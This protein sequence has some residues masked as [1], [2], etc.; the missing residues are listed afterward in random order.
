VLLAVFFG[1]LVF[2]VNAA[3]KKYIPELLQDDSA[4]EFPPLEDQPKNRI[5]IT[6]PAVGPE[7]TS[8]AGMDEGAGTVSEAGSEESFVSFASEAESLAGEGGDV[9][10]ED[11][12]AYQ[13][14]AGSSSRTGDMTDEVDMLP[15]LESL[16]DAFIAA[17]P[18]AIS[19]DSAAH[20]RSSA[21]HR[22]SSGNATIDGPDPQLLA[23]A[24][25]T[26]LNKQQEGK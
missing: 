4:P 1:L 18:S 21:E 10:L 11:A 16:S 26:M 8:P 19:A 23:S 3:L 24:V 5:D 15:D 20:E 17:E 6:L 2:A 22:P 9:P 7:F 13:Q 12:K 25:R 14:R